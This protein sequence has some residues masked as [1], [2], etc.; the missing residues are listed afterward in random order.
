MNCSNNLKQIG[1]GLHNYHSAFKQLPI[2]QG[3]TTG[4]GSGSNEYDPPTANNRLH[5]SWLVG[6]TP[7]IEQQALWEEISNPLQAVVSGGSPVGTF[8]SMGPDPEK[9]LNSH[10]AAGYPPWLTEIPTL[11]C[12]SDPG[13]GLPAHGRTNYAACIGDG[14]HDTN[15]GPLNSAGVESSVRG[16]RTRESCR[17]VFVPRK[18]TAFADIL[19]GLS[20][21]IAGGEINTDLG[22]RD[23]TTQ[24]FDAGGPG[25]PGGVRTNP[26]FCAAFRDPQPCHRP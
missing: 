2:Q 8:Q 7:F 17:G 12:P 19:D 22:D 10:A 1:L 14:I 25:F 20:F 21:T 24:N 3:G 9:S 6:L 23:I 11:R 15:A 16:Q 5:L 26:S 18:G 13:S 4:S